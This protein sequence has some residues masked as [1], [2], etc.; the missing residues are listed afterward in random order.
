MTDIELPNGVKIN[1]NKIQ[2]KGE[3]M[4]EKV[5]NE[6]EKRAN[7]TTQIFR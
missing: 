4:I 1:Y 3:K 7:M 5:E 2:A 6:L